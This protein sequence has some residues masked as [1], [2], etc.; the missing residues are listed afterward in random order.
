MATPGAGTAAR[1]AASP[2]LGGGGGKARNDAVR[3]P[4][5]SKSITSLEPAEVT[6]QENSRAWAGM[7]S[8]QRLQVHA[9]TR[10]SRTESGSRIAA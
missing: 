1:V 9:A 5:A 7:A 10:S 2:P 8:R 4:R 3:R 6:M